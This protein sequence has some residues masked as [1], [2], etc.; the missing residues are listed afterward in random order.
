MA[1]VVLAGCMRM[2]MH[3]VADV[4]AGFFVFGRREPF[5]LHL[6]DDAAPVFDELRRAAVN[7][8]PGQRVLENA[9]KHQRTLNA[10][11]SADVSK[12]ALQHE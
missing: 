6:R 3:Q 8:Q 11:M 5:G 9:A 4:V 7:L 12:S 1:V 10:R 2:R